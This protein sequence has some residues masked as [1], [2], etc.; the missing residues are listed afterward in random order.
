MFEALPGQ[1][2]CKRL[3]FQ[4]RRSVWPLRPSVCR[5]VL[6]PRLRNLAAALLGCEECFLFNDQARQTGAAKFCVG[7]GVA[8][9][10]ALCQAQVPHP[11]GVGR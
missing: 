10:C 1:H 3:D 2:A 7:N 6:G 9:D 8:V 5:L 4:Q 11:G